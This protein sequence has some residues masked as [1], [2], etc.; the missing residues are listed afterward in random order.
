MMLSVSQLIEAA[1]DT[2]N[3]SRW[4][5]DRT[6]TIRHTHI[7]LADVPHTDHWLTPPPRCSFMSWANWR[8][9]G[10][11]A[12]VDRTRLWWSAN[13]PTRPSGVGNCAYILRIERE[14]RHTKI[15]TNLL[16]SKY[17]P[18]AKR[19]VQ[20][21]IRRLSISINRRGNTG[22]GGGRCAPH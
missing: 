21:C 19:H 14:R 3:A 1:L 5:C 7:L 10:G 17:I 2:I 4:R 9:L 22:G 12:L 13:R 15:Y 8:A 20:K 11:A 6:H 16:Y 18:P